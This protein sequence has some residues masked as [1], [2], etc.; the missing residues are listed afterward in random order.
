MNTKVTTTINLYFVRQL[1]PLNL[2]R[3]SRNSSTELKLKSER[4]I[5]AQQKP[6]TLLF[7]YHGNHVCLW[8]NRTS[9]AVNGRADQFVNIRFTSNSRGGDMGGGGGGGGGGRGEGLEPPPPPPQKKNN[10]QQTGW[11]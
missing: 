4:A 11:Y 1:Q 3:N 7:A 6:N 2:D 5:T 8:H 10:P 9:G